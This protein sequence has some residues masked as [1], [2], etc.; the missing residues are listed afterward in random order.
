VSGFIIINDNFAVSWSRPIN[1]GVFLPEGRTEEDVVKAKASVLLDQTTMEIRPKEDVGKS[2]N[3]S[4]NTQDNAGGFASTKFLKRWRSRRFHNNEESKDGCRESK[5]EWNETQSPG[6]G[7]FAFQHGEFDSCKDD[8]RD[9][10]RDKG[11]DSP[12]EA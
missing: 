9:S 5:V 10:G 2:E 4:K 11:C 8:G 3:S 1:P 7:V 6:Q 12:L